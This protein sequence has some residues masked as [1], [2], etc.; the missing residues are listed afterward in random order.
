MKLFLG[1]TEGDLGACRAILDGVGQTSLSHCHFRSIHP[2]IGSPLGVHA[3]GEGISVVGCDF[4]DS[5]KF[6]RV[7][8]ENY[9]NLRL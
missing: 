9:Q 6:V 8:A 1:K 3:K 4:M 2:D 5:V 7:D